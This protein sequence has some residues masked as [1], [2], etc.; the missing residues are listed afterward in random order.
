MHKLLFLLIPIFT[1]TACQEPKVHPKNFKIT[2]EVRLETTPSYG[3]KKQNA[4][5]DTK[6]GY[7]VKDVDFIR[8][9]SPVRIREIDL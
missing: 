5:V 6:A 3:Q 1:F 7:S 2:K 4:G 8:H 9:A